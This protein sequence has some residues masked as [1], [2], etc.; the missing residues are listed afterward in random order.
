MLDSDMTLMRQ[1][2]IEKLDYA[3]SFVE[4]SQYIKEFKLFTKR[5]VEIADEN[6]YDIDNYVYDF[7]LQCTPERREDAYK[8]M[9]STIRQ[10]LKDNDNNLN[11]LLERIEAAKSAV[12]AGRD[13]DAA[14]Y[15]SHQD[16]QS[17]WIE[18]QPKQRERSQKISYLQR[19][20]LFYYIDRAGLR[21]SYS[22]LKGDLDKALDIDFEQSG[23]KSLEKFK[24]LYY[25][26]SR[27]SAE[28]L[29]L[30]KIKDYETVLNISRMMPK[31]QQL[32]KQEI[33]K[34]LDGSHRNIAPEPVPDNKQKHKEDKNTPQRPSTI[35]KY[36]EYCETYNHHTRV[37]KLSHVEAVSKTIS[38]YKINE[39]TLDRALAANI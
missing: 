14:S 21:D 22:Y 16:F 31:E 17:A 9:V 12:D 15:H 39:K 38:K 11:N 35:A 5:H 33:E 3:L 7:L 29:R 4:R 36:K 27:D 20:L 2:L 34:D 37:E 23:L 10:K 32:I 26:I 1:T 8:L 13:I 6:F 28:R 18:A 19:A 24:N 25:L 30:S